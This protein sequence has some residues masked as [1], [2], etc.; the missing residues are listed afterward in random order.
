[1]QQDPTANVLDGEFAF[2][3]DATLLLCG[4]LVIEEAMCD[5]VQFLRKVLPVDRM[6]LQLYEPDLG[7]MRT[8][9]AATAEGGVRLDLLTPLPEV[10]WAYVHEHGEAAA[11]PGASILIFNNP[12]ANRMA[13]FMLKSHH[14]EG[15]SMLRMTL[16]T[17]TGRLAGVVLTARGADRYCERNAHRLSVLREAFAVA[18]TNALEHGDLKRRVDR[19]AAD[20]SRLRDELARSSSVPSGVADR[21]MPGESEPREAAS[22]GG[23]LSARTSPGPIATLDEV[24]AEHIRRALE[25]SGGKVHGRGG[26]GELLGVNPN[27]LR[28]RMRKLGIPHGRRRMQV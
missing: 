24:M 10:A 1:M 28:Y 8:V 5:V 17:E 4:R 18:I 15:S 27:T 3:R 6:F 25:L 16:T 26:A 23:Q 22:A 19:L 12:N 14:I 11:R 21:G 9:A 7:A 13:R 20:N 2:F